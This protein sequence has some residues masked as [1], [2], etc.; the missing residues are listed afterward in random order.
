MSL[1]RVVTCYLGALLACPWLW[2]QTAMRTAVLPAGSLLQVQIDRDA[3]MQVGRP[4]RGHTVYPIYV[5]NQLVVPAGTPVSGE[6]SQVSTAP[7]QRRLDAKLHGDF[8]PLHVAKVRFET[9]ALPSERVAL[10]APPAG[11]GVEVVR[12]ETPDALAHRKSLPARV[13]SDLMNR[14]KSAEA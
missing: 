2:P 9:L 7:H 12:F 4:V 3:K 1:R 14:R 5:D 6:V 13:W 10:N 8:T 11:D